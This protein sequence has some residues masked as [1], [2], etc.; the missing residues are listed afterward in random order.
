MRDLTSSFE[1]E[2]LRYEYSHIEEADISDYPEDGKEYVKWL[3]QVI[4]DHASSIHP[5]YNEYL[6]KEANADELAYYLAQEST[7]D[8]RF[9][10]ILAYMQVGTSAKEKME[11]ASNYWD[12][13]GNGNPEEVHTKLFAR[14]MKDLNVNQSYIQ[15]HMLYDARVSGNLSSA[16]ALSRRHYYKAVGYFGVTEYLAPR[17][18]KH[19]VKAWRRNG[20]PDAGIIY[21]D[22]HIRIDTVHAKAWLNNV[23]APIVD[24]N[25]VLGREIALGAIIRL[26]SSERYLDTMLKVFKSGRVPNRHEYSQAS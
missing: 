16:L 14:A 11:I 7:L 21:H 12:E 18:F 8:P 26:N 19:V 23:I 9:D 24:K 5:L 20:L 6:S 25:P 4:S 1:S 13:M 17:R 15:E 3:Q 10:D 22:L 2:M